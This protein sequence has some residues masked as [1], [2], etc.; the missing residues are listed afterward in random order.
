MPPVKGRM[1]EAHK[2]ALAEGRQLS[3]AVREY[4][5]AIEK[6]RPKRGR[7]RTPESI[8][9]RL[10]TINERLKTA[11]ALERVNLIQERMNLEAEAARLSQKVDLSA[12]ESGFIKAAK[13]YSRRKGITYSAWRQAGVPADVLRRAGI[14]RGFKPDSE[15]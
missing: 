12:L 8:K 9:K 3:A 5:E 1:S 7:K 11:H 10:A 4:L 15:S 14:T 13:D 2:R 6:H